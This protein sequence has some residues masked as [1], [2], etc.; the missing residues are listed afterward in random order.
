MF[1]QMIIQFAQAGD[2]KF[3]IWWAK[4]LGTNGHLYAPITFILIIF[5]AYFYA[6]I[7]FNP[8][9]VAKMLR[10]RGGML[11]GG[12][13]PGKPTSDYLRR[14]NNRLTLF[15][16]IF[17]GFLALIPT[18]ILQQVPGFKTL[19]FGQA[20]S[21]TGLLIVVSVALEFQKQIESQLLVRHNKG[22]LK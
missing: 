18:L 14:I 10:E 6:Q 3:G 12:I 7:Q 9:D 21:A 2:S 16:A 1:P 5:F 22:F 15:G 17:L 20:F 19:G 8:D 13:T 4:W 11:V